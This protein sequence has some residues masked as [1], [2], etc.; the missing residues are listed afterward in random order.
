MIMHRNSGA[1][2]SG[3]PLDWGGRVMATPAQ[4]ATAD[5]L[6]AEGLARPLERRVRDPRG[7]VYLQLARIDPDRRWTTA[8][9]W[10]LAPDGAVVGHGYTLAEAHGQGRLARMRR[11]NE[12]LRPMPAAQT[13]G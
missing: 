4:V 6:I 1:V 8:G 12:A 9:R 11:L 13:A 5:R 7:K 2:N 10:Y 3:Y